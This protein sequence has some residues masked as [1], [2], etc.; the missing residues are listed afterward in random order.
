[1]RWGVL[2]DIHGNLHALHA[3]VADL[4]VLGVD[5]WLSVGDLVGYGPQPNECVE[6]VLSLGARGVAGNHDLIALGELSGERSSERAKRSH[7]W[8]RDE[9]RPDVLDHLRML[10]RT[11]EVDGGLVL[12]HGSLDDPEEYV[13]LARQASEQLR[14]LRLRH[15]EA[16]ALLLGNTH[17]QLLHHEGSARVKP[18]RRSPA[19]LGSGP[20]V[21]NPGS[22]GQSRQRERHPQARALLLDT[23]SGEAWFRAV[24]YD[25][26][27]CRAELVRR[28]L[29]PES[30]HAPPR[31]RVPGRRR[32]GRMV[33]R[34][35]RR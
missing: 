1:M 32:A 30:L 29:P 23:A 4:Q 17:E 10:P 16:R 28:G 15:P 11:L 3:V 27:G 35:L 20:V 34:V 26:E 14:N 31:R 13:Y 18:P 8:T 5:G 22:V 24:D 19:P 2:S 21:L 25:V 33:R 9:L 6:L 7:L 12:A